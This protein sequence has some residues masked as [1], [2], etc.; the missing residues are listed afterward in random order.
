MNKDL[1]LEIILGI[2]A[3]DLPILYTLY[4]MWA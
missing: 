3:F 1:I 4:V 2:I